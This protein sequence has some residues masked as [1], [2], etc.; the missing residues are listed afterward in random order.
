MLHAQQAAGLLIER[1]ELVHQVTDDLHCHLVAL[2]AVQLARLESLDHCFGKLLSRTRRHSPEEAIVAFVAIGTV[3]LHH[4]GVR[5]EVH[6]RLAAGSE[7]LLE[8]TAV[9]RQ[10]TVQSGEIVEVHV[11]QG[12]QILVRILHE[13]PP[14]KRS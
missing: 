4:P 2:G 9:G 8:A 14:G 11:L 3:A 5:Q 10:G 13:K 7:R 1:V 12:I 6:H